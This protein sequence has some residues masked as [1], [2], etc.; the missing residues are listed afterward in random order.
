MYAVI[1]RSHNIFRQMKK[2]ILVEKCPVEEITE[3]QQVSYRD[4]MWQNTNNGEQ[5]QVV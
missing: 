3:F 1:L 4:Q 5:G 2:N